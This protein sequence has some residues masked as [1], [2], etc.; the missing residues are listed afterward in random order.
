MAASKKEMQIVTV[1][2]MGREYEVD[3]D[4]LRS[5]KLNRAFANAGKDLARAYEA[6]DAMCCGHLDDYADTIPEED[7]TVLAY[8]A[9]FAALNAFLGAAAEQAVNAKN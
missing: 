4:A 5:V 3:S 7:G 1:N 8:G 6:M 2:Y 9:S